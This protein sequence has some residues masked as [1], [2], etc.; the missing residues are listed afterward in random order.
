MRQERLTL[1]EITNIC[2][3]GAEQLKSLRRRDQIA[4]AFGGNTAWAVATWYMPADCVGLM[5]TTALAQAYDMTVAAQLVRAFG[6]QWLHAVA[7]AEAAET[8][9][10]FDAWFAVADLVRRDDGSRSL[11]AWCTGSVTLAGLPEANGPMFERITMINISRIV[12]AVRVNAARCDLDLSAPFMPAPDSDDFQEIMAAYAR[13]T[14]G[15]VE[16][17]ALKKAEASA[18]RLGGQAR[19]I[20]MRRRG[21]GQIPSTRDLQMA[22]AA[23]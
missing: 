2:D 22:D 18:R 13:E 9:A 16:A 10:G 21:S 11:M 19:A 17:R 4:L 14:G 6:A 3:I 7:K 23:A 12:R 20:M 8:D 5:L 15:F 1:D